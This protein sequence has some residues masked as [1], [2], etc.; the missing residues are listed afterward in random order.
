MLIH[1]VRLMEPLRKLVSRKATKY[2]LRKI[3]CAHT[4]RAA[5]DGRLLFRTLCWCFC[6]RLFFRLARR[7]R[8]HAGERYFAR[9]DIIV[10]IRASRVAPSNQVKAHRNLLSGARGMTRPHNNKCARGVSVGAVCGEYIRFT[11]PISHAHI[12]R[13]WTIFICSLHRQE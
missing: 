8:R 6:V 9:R 12:K 3:L 13:G 5:N 2:E 10:L 1:A 11:S 7:R 4:A